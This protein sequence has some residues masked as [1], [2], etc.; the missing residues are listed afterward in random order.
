M[1]IA[2][3]GP[4]RLRLGSPRYTLT[5]TSREENRC[6]ILGLPAAGYRMRGVKVQRI[7]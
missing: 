4:P 2:P 1:S 7:D 3:Q 5:L 6:F